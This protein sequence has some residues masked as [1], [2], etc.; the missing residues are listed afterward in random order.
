[1][2]QTSE[3]I[4]LSRAFVQDPWPVYRQLRDAAPVQRAVLTGGV[5]V[6]LITGYD[7]ARAL[8]ADPRLS[9]D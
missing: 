9:T 8:L 4:A 5:P 2:H 1:M 6:W 3:L 7:E